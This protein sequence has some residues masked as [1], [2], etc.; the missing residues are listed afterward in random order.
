[1]HNPKS[2]PENDTHTQILGDFDIQTH[3]LISAR[4]PDL[5]ILN[6]KENVQNVDF[7]VPT[8]HRVK[9][10]E[11]K[12]NIYLDLSRELKKTV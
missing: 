2:I 1:M 8:D 5:I 10:K 9:L 4:L 6:K 12:K 7:A 11:I 3:H